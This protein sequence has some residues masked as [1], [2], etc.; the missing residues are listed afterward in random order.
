[1]KIVVF[2]LPRVVT[3]RVFAR[4][5]YLALNGIQPVVFIA[6]FRFHQVLYAYPV[7]AAHPHL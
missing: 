6:E 4:A 1:M 7:R 2:A 5:V 3:F